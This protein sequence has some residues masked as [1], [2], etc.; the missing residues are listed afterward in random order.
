MESDET[1][2]FEFIDVMKEYFGDDNVDWS[3]PSVHEREIYIRTLP[4][5]T[6]PRVAATVVTFSDREGSSWNPVQVD[7]GEAVYVALREHF[8]GLSF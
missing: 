8:P 6:G 7:V 4:K 5:G 1:K 2:F 3:W